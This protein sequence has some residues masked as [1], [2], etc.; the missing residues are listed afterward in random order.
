V[1][2]VMVVEGLKRSKKRGIAELGTE[3]GATEGRERAGPEKRP[4]SQRSYTGE[5]ERQDPSSPP[6]RT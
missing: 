4:Q 2:E 3:W 1:S 5:R 6:V